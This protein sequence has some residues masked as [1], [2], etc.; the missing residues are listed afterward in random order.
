M[1]SVQYSTKQYD[2]SYKLANG[3]LIQ[4]ILDPNIPKEGD[5]TSWTKVVILNTETGYFEVV[6][7]SGVKYVG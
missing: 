4:C 5:F 1:L 7:L 3:K 6:N 2:G